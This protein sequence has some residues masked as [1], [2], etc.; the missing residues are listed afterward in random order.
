LHL[1]HHDGGAE[2]LHGGD[3]FLCVLLGDILLHELRR[4]LDELLAVHQA[5]TQQTLDFLDDLGLGCG[6][7]ALELEVEKR[8]LRGGGSGVLGIF[9]CGRGGR[10]SGEAAN[11]EVGDVELGLWSWPNRLAPAAHFRAQLQPE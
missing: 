9:N 4:A 5:E 6:I 7:E 11:R 8:L 10:S 2:L 3:H 1:L